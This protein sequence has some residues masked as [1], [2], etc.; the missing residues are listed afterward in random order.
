M[1]RR[2]Q[3]STPDRGRIEL[4]LLAVGALA[5]AIASRGACA[6]EPVVLPP[7]DVVDTAK[8]EVIARI[9]AGSRSNGV[10]AHPDGKRVFVTSG[11]K[12]TVQ[13]IDTATNTI[14]QEIPVGRRPWN[15]ALTPDGRKLYVACGRSNAV[16]VIDTATYKKIAE[17][18][19]GEL[20]W[21]VAIN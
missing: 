3:L 20:P 1:G 5:V 8:H 2:N 12:G 10:L 7:I 21:G 14:V 11:G 19:V 13:V 4:A 16:A 6:E 9:K 17:I 18:P 15:M